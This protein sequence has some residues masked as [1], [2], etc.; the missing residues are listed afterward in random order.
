M[1]LGIEKLIYPQNEVINGQVIMQKL[2]SFAFSEAQTGLW[3]PER[4]NGWWC[5]CIVHPSMSKGSTMHLMIASLS[6]LKFRIKKFMAWNKFPPHLLPNPIN[7]HVIHVCIFLF[8]LSLL[9]LFLL[10]HDPTTM[11]RIWQEGGELT[12]MQGRLWKMIWQIVAYVEFSC[13]YEA[14]SVGMFPSVRF[15]LWLWVLLAFSICLGLPS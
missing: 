2:L 6:P 14:V 1:I 9:Y 7:A 11:G 5:A 15:C 4:R 3:H 10:G 8:H 12:R 13:S